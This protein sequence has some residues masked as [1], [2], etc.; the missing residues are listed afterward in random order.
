[1]PCHAVS[2]RAMPCHVP[3][4]PCRAMACLAMS[5]LHA[6]PCEARATHG[7]GLR[8]CIWA[9]VGQ[10]AGACLQ[11]L[12]SYPLPCRCRPASRQSPWAAPA[13]HC[14]AAVLTSLP[15]I[16]AQVV[17]RFPPEPNGYLHIGH[18]K[19]GCSDFRAPLLAAL[20]PEAFWAGKSA[21]LHA[22][23]SSQAGLMLRYARH[24]SMR[25]PCLWTSE[26]RAS[27]MVCACCA[28]T[29]P[30]RRRRS[31]CGLEPCFPL[32]QPLCSVGVCLLRVDGTNPEAE[33][34]V[35][36]GTLLPLISIVLFSQCVPAAL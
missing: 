14:Q 10:G 21:S 7:L 35:R 26:W 32:F 19:V 6:T 24:T 29:T 31:R 11:P 17:T 23:C 33:K 16:A 2:C 22:V 28:L 30:T 3:A 34:Q 8:P 5:L 13:C 18:A 36:S 25:R 15:P 9:H 27:T 4:M 1:M 12:H 20:S